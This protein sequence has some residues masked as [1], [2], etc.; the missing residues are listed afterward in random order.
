MKVIVGPGKGDLD[1]IVEVGEGVVG[2]DDQSPPDHRVNAP[3]PHM[4]LI[5]RRHGFLTHGCQLNNL[6]MGTPPSLKFSPRFVLVSNRGFPLIDTARFYFSRPSRR[7]MCYCN[8]MLR[9]RPSA[10]GIAKPSK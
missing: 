4:Y 10:V 8:T 5:R 7:R 2:A 9:G 3:D 6:R 1:D